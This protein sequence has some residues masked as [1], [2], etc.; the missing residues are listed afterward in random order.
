MK[1]S[2][3]NYWLYTLIFMGLVV[4][5]YGIFILTGKSFI[6]EGDGLAQH[7]PVLEKFYTWLHGGSLSG[8]S[9]NLGLGADK[10]TTFSYYVLGD[11]FSY[12][13]WFFPKHSIELGYNLL[14][15]LRLYVSGLAFMLF[16][17][18][19]HFKPGS[20]MLGTLTYTFTGY[21]LYVSIR[22]PFFLLP[23]ILFPLLAYGIDHIYQGKTWVPLAIFT[24]L[25]LVS[26]FYF[27]YILAI[28]SLVY[29]VLRY[30][31]VRDTIVQKGWPLIFKLVGAGLAGFLLA[32]IIFI[33][34][35]IGV[36][37]STR[38]TGNFANG[39]LIYPFSYYLRLP[40]ALVTTGNPMRFWANLGLAGLTFL[41][42]MYVVRHARRYLWFDI[43]LLILV[44]GSLLPEVAAVMNGGTTPSQRWLL[45]GCLAF[46]LAV[47]Y[48]IDAL[49]RLDR[50]DI[51]A[52]I[53]GTL[54]LLGLVWMANG[55]IFNNNP[56]DLVI[57][58]L[59]LLTLGA[60]TVG[61]FYQ[62]S[63]HRVIWT[64]LT[65]LFLNILANGYGYFSPNAGGASNQ[66]LHR[67]VATK[68]QK[69]F[70]DG[71]ESYVKAQPGFKRSS[72]SKYYYY[73]NE[74]KTNMGMNL[75]AH[76]IM[77]YFSIQ[78]GSVGEFSEELA[79]SQFKMNKPINQ[80][81]SRTT[82]NN[83]LG[84]N[85][86]FARS[87]QLKT[88]GFPYGYSPVK[89]NGKVLKYKDQP[90]HDLGN[91]YDTVILKSKYAL[92]LAYLQT[93]QLSTQQFKQLN[94]SDKEQALT[95]GALPEKKVQ[96]VAT[97][98]YQSHHQNLSYQT[99]ADRSTVLDNLKQVMTFRQQGN[100][101]DPEK[102]TTTKSSLMQTNQDRAVHI[103]DDKARLEQ[104]TKQNR[105][106]LKKNRVANRQTLHKMMSD[107]QNLPVTYRL[108]LK[109]PKQN[110]GTEMYLELD[111]ID[112]QRLTVHDK[113]LAAKNTKAFGNQAFSGIER[114]NQIRSGLWNQSDGAYSVTATTSNNVSSFSQFGQ[115]NLSDYQEKHHVLL[116]LGYSTKARHNI[117]L[118]FQGVKS[119]SFKSAKVIAVPFGSQYG[120]RMTQ[121]KKQG[122]QDLNVKDN[123]VTGTS[124]S[125]Q[126]SV[127][128]TSIPYNTGWHLTVDGKQRPITKVNVGFVGAR[129]SAGTHKVVLTYRTPGQRL[130]LVMTALGVL[131]MIVTGGY[132]YWWRRRH[133]K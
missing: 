12:L 119:L 41:S 112:A 121:L 33:P 123:R 84:V 38:A 95:Y 129:L 26:N 108:H 45:L 56:H 103:T 82:M 60:I 35:L 36:F 87:N 102:I 15:L 51:S 14:I 16:A 42:L 11:P 111:G 79:N 50:S 100:Q 64:L 74:A 88:Q 120:K 89:K 7:Y 115:S 32:G 1:V 53:V 47:M 113:Y 114:I 78:D 65:L 48:F 43:G 44:I 9:W 128:T 126:A 39:Y 13:I 40:N 25:A 106:A 8:W 23:M 132:T 98:K 57:Y 110:K 85:Y 81:D 31:S 54:V 90:V 21:S 76:D 72:I 28:G 2:K 49:P 96:G 17:R 131:V 118:T 71:A 63:R 27:A 20:Q 94:G 37:T 107:N 18:Q 52:M 34:S 91:N 62:W 29:A 24:G 68:F 116:N 69:N 109:H 6:W 30:F 130:G 3:K 80:A 75:G 117:K 58:G 124:Q 86:I 92:P 127:L 46:S 93:K 73:S 66:L 10:M 22:H 77:S 61:H 55:F 122:L 19:R 105:T 101:M 5:L 97:T 125:T 67:G 99:R 4:C 83:L 70:Y 133:L 59:L 104:L